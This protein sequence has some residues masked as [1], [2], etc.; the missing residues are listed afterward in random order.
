MHLLM[1]YTR[2][3][4]DQP[5]STATV[6]TNTTTPSASASTST[7]VSDSKRKRTDVAGVNAKEHNA[8]GSGELSKKQMKKLKLKK[9][10]KA[11]G[12]K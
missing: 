1:L 11:S 9:E 7:S 4:Y 10:A 3:G 6:P 2:V 5:R 8:G 12:G